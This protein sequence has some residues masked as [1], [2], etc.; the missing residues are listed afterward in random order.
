MTHYKT[1]S[2]IT[3]HYNSTEQKKHVALLYGGMSEEY[4]VS[5]LSGKN[6][7]NILL[8]LNYS[9][10]S[11]D[12]GSD[13]S[14]ILNNMRPDVVFN[15]LHG[16]YGEDGSI[17]GV[18]NILKI[19]YT[20]SGLLA[21][22][23]GLNKLFSKKLFSLNGISTIPHRLVNKSDNLTSDPMERPYVIKPIS[24]GSSKGIIIVF[25]EDSF[26]FANYLF[27]FGDTVLIE[28]YIKGV[29]VQ[30]AVLDGKSLGVLELEIN[31]SKR[32]YDFET[33]Y[34]DGFAKHILPA[35]LEETKYN[36]VMRLG[37]LAYDSIFARGLARVEF[38]YCEEK[39]NEE[40]F[41]ILEINTHPG[42]TEQSIFPEIANYAGIN[43]NQLVEIL[44][45]KACYDL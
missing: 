20:H 12:M 15:A 41:Y 2:T 34:T 22:S 6:I 14:E 9:V 37:E 10:T 21:S 40:I 35:R 32:F 5:V 27:E 3:L 25:K 38:I 13:I 24:Q 11:I 45:E 39:E 19:P 33:K 16:T 26:S 7:E 36:Q 44:L 31:P 29:E 28:K 17:Q 43:K 42:F 4:D 30:V 1:K 18:C 23:L 8:E